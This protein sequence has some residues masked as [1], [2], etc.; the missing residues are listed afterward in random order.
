M[1]KPVIISSR[2]TEEEEKKIKSAAKKLKLPLAH[3]QSKAVM[4]SVNEI[5]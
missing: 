4:D 5:K 3:F 1:K 2:Y